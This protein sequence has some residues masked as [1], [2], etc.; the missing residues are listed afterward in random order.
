MTNLTVPCGSHQKVPFVYVNKVSIIYTLI[1]NDFC[2][3][4]AE[5]KGEAEED[6]EEEEEEEE[7]TPEEVIHF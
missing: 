1:S 3:Q 2:K 5:A 4:S 7:E 6:A